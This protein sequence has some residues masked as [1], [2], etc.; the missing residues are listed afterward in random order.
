MTPPGRSPMSIRGPSCRSLDH[1]AHAVAGEGVAEGALGRTVEF[2]L[3]AGGHHPLTWRSSVA[4]LAEHATVNR[5]VT[6]SSP[7]GGAKLLV[8]GLVVRDA[9]DRHM[10]YT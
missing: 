7:V 3:P 6:G 9:V 8:E 10:T 4:Q 2:S 1:R 5:R